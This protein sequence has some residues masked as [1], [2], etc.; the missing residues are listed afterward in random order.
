MD[1]KTAVS[2]EVCPSCGSF[3]VRAIEPRWF[4]VDV[5]RRSELDRG[6]AE[7][8]DFACRDCGLSWT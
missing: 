5:D 8:I 6:W 1:G 7:H 2:A 4:Q 3:D